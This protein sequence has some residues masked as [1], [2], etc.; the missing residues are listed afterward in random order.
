MTTIKTLSVPH[1]TFSLTIEGHGTIKSTSQQLVEY[2]KSQG[3]VSDD[4]VQQLE[5]LVSMADTT[6]L[7]THTLHVTLTKSCD[8]IIQRRRIVASTKGFGA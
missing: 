2:T 4:T 8:F 3:Q 6:N 5:A 1:F 7:K